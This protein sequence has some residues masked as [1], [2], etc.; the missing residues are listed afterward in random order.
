MGVLNANLLL[1]YSKVDKRCPQLGKIAK[2]WAKRRLVSSK[3]NY[4]SYAVIYTNN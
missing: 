3:T 2:L 4:S 1:A